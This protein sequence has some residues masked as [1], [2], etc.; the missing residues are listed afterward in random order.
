M[1]QVKVNPQDLRRFA[2]FLDELCA[3]LQHKKRNTAHSFEQLRQTWK[4]DKC[5]QFEKTFAST[6]QDLDQFLKMTKAYAEF[7]RKKAA[8]LDTYLRLR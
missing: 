3:S 4:D 5:K 2:V 1:P 6:S 7:L 8:K